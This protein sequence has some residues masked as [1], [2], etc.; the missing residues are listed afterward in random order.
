[1]SSPSKIA[2]NRA[3]S[4]H[5]TGPKTAE[6]LAASKYNATRHGLTGKNIVT[7]G[8]DPSA[9]D[10][11]RESLHAEWSPASENEA[12]LVEEV[13]QNWWRLQRA[14]RM[15][16]ELIDELGGIATLIDRYFG[17][18]FDRIQ[19]Y[20]RSNERAWNRARAELTKLQQTRRAEEAAACAAQSP[21]TQ[22]IRTAA[23]SVGFVSQ[24][25][26][27]LRPDSDPR[28]QAVQSGTPCNPESAVVV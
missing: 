23:A 14:R 18:A 21:Q 3:N 10:A 24:T 16:S 2:A 9:Y 11:L 22:Q 17:V 19:R 13:A 8:E 7:K 28:G 27:A 15:E 12:M 26:S 25:P 4:Q 20:I 1:M 5:S 6:G